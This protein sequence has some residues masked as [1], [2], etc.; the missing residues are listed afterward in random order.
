MPEAQRNSQAALLLADFSELYQLSPQ[1]SIMQIYKR[2]PGS[3]VFPGFSFSRSPLVGYLAHTSIVDDFSPLVRGIEDSRASIYIALSDRSGILLGRLNLETLQRYLRQFASAAQ[4]PVM[5]VASDGSIL[6]TSDPSLRIPAFSL[7]GAW[8]RQVIREPLELAGQRWMP[9]ITPARSVG[10][11][12]VTLVPTQR[13]AEEQ[14][15]IITLL[16]GV[17]IASGVLLALKSLRMRRLFIQP[18]VRLAGH[19]RSLEAGDGCSEGNFEDSFGMQVAEAQKE[20]PARFA[21]LETI[22]R[23]F[24]AMA[25]AI[26]EREQKLRQSEQQHRLLADNAL[27]VITI[28]EPTGRPTYISPSIEKVRGWSAAEAMALPM[29]LH[30]RPEGCSVLRN[31]LEQTQEAVRRALPLPSFRVELQQSH[32]TGTWIW[33]DVTISCIVDEAGVY[34]GTLLV[35]R[36]ISERKRLE[37]ELYQRAACDELTGLLNRR[38]LLEK[39]EALLSQPDRRVSDKGLAL[40]FCDLDLFKEIN[41]TLGHSVGDTVLRTTAQRI[42]GCLRSDDL[43][44]GM[45]G[46][47]MVVVLRDISDLDAAMAIAEKINRAIAKP[48]TTVEPQ[49]GITASIGVTLARSQEGLDELMARADQA[50]YQAKQAGRNC[51]TRIL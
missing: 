48:I 42:C 5:I 29:D 44:A 1:L 45:G 43:A 11:A 3:Q 15:Q 46:D 27:D 9:I 40:L 24:V 49:V 18:I 16:A 30:L 33:T 36:D 50:M 10:A 21:E 47:E 28:C 22:Q 19:M 39:L 38:A 8:K 20:P 41:D 7:N 32:K 17:S 31:A 35:Y 2:L 23:A 51:V 25:R 34:I 6:L 12:I 37:D 14:Q 26:R 4:T 13:L